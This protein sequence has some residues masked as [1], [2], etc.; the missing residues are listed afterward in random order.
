MAAGLITLLFSRSTYTRI[1]AIPY[2][3]VYGI[4]IIGWLSSLFYTQFVANT[5]LAHRFSFSA[6]YIFTL[7]MLGLALTFPNNTPRKLVRRILTL[8]GFIGLVLIGLIFFT[9]YVLTAANFSGAKTAHFSSLGSIYLLILVAHLVS[10]ITVFV[11]RYLMEVRN[12]LYFNYIVLA[13]ILFFLIAA[14]TNLILP[15]AGVVTFTMLGPLAALIPFV[16]VVY[17]L[18]ITDI[19]DVNYIVAQLLQL[20]AR[21]VAI[22][23][24]FLVGLF[25]A[26]VLGISYY[27]SPWVISMSIAAVGGVLLFYLFGL[28][29]DRYVDNRIAYSRLSPD[30]ARGEL[31]LGLSGE[32]ELDRNAIL[33]LKLIKQ[34]IGVRSASIALLAKDDTFWAAGELTLTQTNLRTI[35]DTIT[36][37]PTKSAVN[38]RT[39]VN[40]NVLPPEI[41]QALET[42]GIYAVKLL[43]TE[44]GIAGLY[45][46]GEKFSQEIFTRQDATLMHAITE[47]SDLSIERALFYDQIQSFNATLQQRIDDATQKL[48]KANKRLKTLDA[49]KD[50]FIS[51]ASHQL[52]SP[53]SSVH[54]AIKMLEQD[55]LS[56]VERQR[57]IELADASSERLV[58]VITDMLSVARIQAGHFTL[59]KAAVNIAELIDRAIL[60][61]GA[62]AKQKSITLEVKKP[63]EPVVVYV[64][65][66][67]LN[68][69]I[70]NYIENAI[71]YSGE[72]TVVHIVL[73]RHQS[74]TDLTVRDEGIGVP[75]SE[76][77]HLFTKFY[78]ATNARQEQPNGNGIGLF[79]VKTIIK[80]HGGDVY[81]EPQPRGSLFGFWL[82]L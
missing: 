57:I 82:P 67:R 75:K 63:S 64:D 39:L 23:M 58:N 6:A 15:L 30:K 60:E 25:L 12:R 65:R 79:V 34:A 52:R 2:A 72:G 74:R 42:E 51:M 27:S 36:H 49:L 33:V 17:A 20:G 1:K 48:R 81:Y 55:Y 38:G 78:R 7:G 10:A 68:E 69:V 32:I 41:K 24:L 29:F 28:S 4:G 13:F 8:D 53:A 22:I 73:S 19:N 77:K 18:G 54:D 9:N 50:D 70:A 37:L 16:A 56:P 80:E 47:I 14:T 71:R 66:A 5:F 21:L 44:S 61:A 3:F 46:L 35:L 76:T 43:H 11:R 40:V 26:R 59:E 62:L 45:L 31:I